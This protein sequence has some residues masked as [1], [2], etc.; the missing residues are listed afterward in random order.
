VR[1]LFA[2]LLSAAFAIAGDWQNYANF[3]P[4]RDSAL[5]ADGTLW[6]ATETGICSVKNGNS[7]Y[8][9]TAEG[10]EESAQALIFVLKDGTI[11]SVSAHGLIAK[12]NKTI[13]RSYA[14]S[15]RLVEKGIGLIL[16]TVLVIPFNGALAYYDIPQNRSLLTLTRLAT[17]DLASVA[18]DS[19]SASARGDSLFVALSNGKIYAQKFNPQDSDPLSW[20]AVDTM[21]PPSKNG[22][23][24]EAG[25]VPFAPFNLE[26]V[27]TLALFPGGDV[28]G[29]GW[30]YAARFRDGAWSPR[31]EANPT[32]YGDEWYNYILKSLAVNQKRNI[33]IGFW[34]AGFAIHEADFEPAQGKYAAW[35]HNIRNASCLEG[36]YEGGN[37]T[38][39]R[40]AVRAP[41]STGFLFSYV[42]KDSYGLAYA[43]ADGT[44]FCAPHVGNSAWGG[45]LTV[46]KNEAGD[47]E[48]FVVWET[49]MNSGIGGFEI[50]TA[51]PP[52]TSFAPTLLQTLTS[53]IGAPR[54]LALDTSGTLWAATP[55]NLA[56]YRLGDTAFTTPPYLQ[57]YTGGDLHA[58][59]ADPNGGLWLATLDKGAYQIQK[60]RGKNDSL[61]FARILP[62]D[63]LLSEQVYDIAIDP[64]RGHVWFGTDKGVSLFK[65]AG[66]KDASQ[67]M[68]N[69]AAQVFAYPNP[70]RPQE[71]GSVRIENIRSGATLYLMDGAGG[72]I[73]TWNSK[74]IV[75]GQ[76]QW[77]GKNSKGK[78][79][80]PGLY[81]YFAVSGKHKHHGKIVL[82]W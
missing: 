22:R 59:E 5:A 38:L 70:F 35:F 67:L 50:F 54:D 40:G 30:N 9:T 29:L 14:E 41:D 68:Q 8:Y 49:G 47:W 48:I 81:H 16:D 73:R 76:V 42:Q 7:V 65:T 55:S 27:N 66:V 57:G 33:G 74:D 52:V 13:H 79:V 12:N 43:R 20:L 15:G 11:L 82:Q 60:L 46:Q 26:R 24:I 64:V 72:R 36:G 69:G 63:G 3:W 25:N 6:L 44:I 2:L 19:V 23:E 77:D 1:I 34:G 78:S 37:Y 53:T 51:P 4:V 31:F 18:I 56:Y 21:P 61:S 71:H 28:V 45:P 32:G 10:L 39:V 58:L 62:K 80:A 17:E 75:G